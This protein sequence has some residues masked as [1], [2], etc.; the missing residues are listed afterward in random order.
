MGPDSGITTQTLPTDLSS[1][2]DRI[3]KTVDDH[4][5]DDQINS[6]TETMKI[7]RITETEQ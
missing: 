1:I 7:D 3:I 5:T 6:P 2:M 4:L